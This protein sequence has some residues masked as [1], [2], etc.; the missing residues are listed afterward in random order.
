MKNHCHD[1]NSDYATPGTCNCFAVGGKRYVV[2]ANT[3]PQYP[4]YPSWYPWTQYDTA[5][6]PATSGTV[7]I[8]PCIS[9]ATGITAADVATAISYAFD[10]N[11]NVVA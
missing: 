1:C 5:T 8:T 4:W 6:S 3:L 2:P 9:T 7:T 10:N 11:G